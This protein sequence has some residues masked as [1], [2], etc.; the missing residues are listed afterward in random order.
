MIF[1]VGTDLITNAL[2]S[3]SLDFFFDTSF[4][5]GVFRNDDLKLPLRGNL[6]IHDGGTIIFECSPLS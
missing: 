3:F 1:V 5:R 4:L 2:D 6:I